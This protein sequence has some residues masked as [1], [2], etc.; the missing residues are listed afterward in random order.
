MK[1]STREWIGQAEEDFEGALDLA[2]RRRKPLWSRVCFFC[3]QCAEK[4]LKAR[5]NEA[6]VF[7]AKTHDLEALLSQVV[8]VEPLWSTFLPTF[9]SLTDYAVKSRYPG[10]PVTKVEARKALADC[11]AFRLEA[12]YRLGLPRK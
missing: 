5:L 12:R 11:K 4:Y 3:H 9:K 2:R 7:F 8:A 6:G 1:R 10:N